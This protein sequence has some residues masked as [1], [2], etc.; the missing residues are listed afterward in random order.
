MSD[1][2]ISNVNPATQTLTV[3]ETQPMVPNPTAR[4]T[5]PQGM[6]PAFRQLLIDLSLQV[7]VS[8]FFISMAI[9]CLCVSIPAIHARPYPEE[10]GGSS[11]QLPTK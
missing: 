10:Q 1:D 6:S 4:V 7:V 2:P 11:S 9:I 8:C 5:K 3:A